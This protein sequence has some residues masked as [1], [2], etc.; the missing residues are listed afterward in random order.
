MLLLIFVHV[1]QINTSTIPRKITMV[2]V[3]MS[4]YIAAVQG[5]IAPNPVFG[6]YTNNSSA[7]LQTNAGLRQFYDFGFY[8]YCAYVDE[9]AGIC[10]N[11]TVGQRFTPY[12]VVTSDMAPNYSTIAAAIIPENTFTDSKYLGNTSQAGYWLIL[13]GTICAALAL[14]TGIAKNHLTF[15]LSA[16]F[17]LLGSLLLLIGASLWTVVIKKSQVINMAVNPNNQQL[18]R[19]TV[20]EGSGLF[21]TWAAFVVLLASVIPYFISCCTWRG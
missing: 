18:L 4:D 6:L 7:P 2:K 16:I 9:N 8:S 3:N 17:S 10:G 19:I 12:D 1:G 15:F 21:I 11:H 20:T 14:I 13:L 5:A